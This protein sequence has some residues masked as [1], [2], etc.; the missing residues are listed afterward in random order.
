MQV[1]LMHEGG[2]NHGNE[3]EVNSPEFVIGR[4]DSCNLTLRSEEVSR[5]HCTLLIRGDSLWL[6][7]ESSRNGTYINRR[8]MRGEFQLDAG[9]TIQI[10][11]F[12]FSVAVDYGA[13]EAAQQIIGDE[14]N[15]PGSG[16][17]TAVVR[18]PVIDPAELQEEEEARL[19]D[20]LSDLRE[21]RPM[22]EPPVQ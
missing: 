3:V 15:E 14:L 10:G 5:V 18:A 12:L 8:G 21:T 13:P 22:D 11:S 2:P 16:T 17:K 4:D 7:D 6:R 1:T 9:D 20:R 19:E